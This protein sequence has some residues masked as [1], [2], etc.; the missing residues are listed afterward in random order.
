MLS[1]FEFSDEPFKRIREEMNQLQSQYARLEHV[2]RSACRLLNDYHPK[3]IIRELEK[4]VRQL[5]TATS[6]EQNAKLKR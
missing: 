4:L 1:S 6:E 3:N 5:K 2:S